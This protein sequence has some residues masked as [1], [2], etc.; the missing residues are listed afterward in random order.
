ME[1]LTALSQAYVCFLIFQLF[2]HSEMFAGGE[3]EEEEAA[4]CFHSGLS[5]VACH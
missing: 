4:V 5:F 3:D 1:S 2:T